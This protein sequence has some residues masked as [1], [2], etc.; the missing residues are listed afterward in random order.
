[1]NQDRLFAV[2]QE[3]FTTDDY[4]TP[5]WIFDALEL[6][7]DLDVAAPQEGARHTPCR[8]HYSQSTD[9][10]AQDWEGVV[11]MNPPYSKA[12]PWVKKFM[13]HKNGVALL[14]MA[15]SQW[16][17]DL[18]QDC[19]AL[20]V[21]PKETLFEHAEHLRGSI[22]LPVVLAAYGAQSVKA[23]YQSKIGRVR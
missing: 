14:P 13:L 7:F 18:W 20:V 10:L 11:F 2:H 4:Y 5:A 1:M 3:L 21:L 23:L 17:N 8:H 15:K 22:F 19:E 6:T 16:F 12:T 9:G